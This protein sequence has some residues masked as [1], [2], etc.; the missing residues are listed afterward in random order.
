MDAALS[1]HALY[2]VGLSTLMCRQPC[3]SVCNR[4]I[5][6]YHTCYDSRKLSKD[7]G[8]QCT[9]D[10]ARWACYIAGNATCLSACQVPVR[11]GARHPGGN[12]HL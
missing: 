3:G 9:Q 2:A 7:M 6:G 12:I 1:V 10:K 5:S 8:Q 11:E 4:I